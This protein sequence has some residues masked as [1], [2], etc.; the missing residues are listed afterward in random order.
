MNG[1]KN[2]SFIMTNYKKTE[3]ILM[4]ITFADDKLIVIAIIKNDCINKLISS[5]TNILRFE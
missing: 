2:I 1:L 5:L 4:N 3:T